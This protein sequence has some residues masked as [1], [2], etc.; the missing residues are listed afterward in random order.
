MIMITGFGH[1]NINP[2]SNNVISIPNHQLPPKMKHN[3]NQ[4]GVL[5]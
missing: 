4:G 3:L 1:P 2:H 5:R